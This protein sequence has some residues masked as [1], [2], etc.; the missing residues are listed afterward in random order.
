M[1]LRKR[2]A[3]FCKFVVAEL[4]ALMLREAHLLQQEGL[5]GAQS[6]TH[7]NV[8]V[9]VFDRD[10]RI[11]FVVVI[12]TRTILSCSAGRSTL[13]FHALLSTLFLQIFELIWLYLC[14]WAGLA[15]LRFPRL[16]HLCERQGG[17]HW[18][19]NGLRLDLVDSKLVIQQTPLD[20][21]MLRRYQCKL[22]QLVAMQMH[23][24]RGVG[25][26]H[27]IHRIVDNFAFDWGLRG[28]HTIG[29]QEFLGLLEIVF[30]GIHSPDSVDFFVF[31]I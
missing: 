10:L 5:D 9:E 19:L 17:S 31:W 7:A 23:C 24:E 18:L 22:D 20:D 12:A 28:S 15:M 16:D 14:N 27:S 26:A 11:I 30:A 6:R 3:H 2:L 8:A 1:V 21:H 29:K 4:L 13:L 25:Q